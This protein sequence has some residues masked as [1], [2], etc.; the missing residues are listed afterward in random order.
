M[1][2]PFKCPKCGGPY[3]G[4]DTA[5][6]DGKVAFLNTVACHCD[7]NGGALSFWMNSESGELVPRVPRPG[8][9]CGWRG[10]WD[11]NWEGA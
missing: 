4:R 7:E 3:C 8:K 2:H 5:R 9:P 11:T 10:E 6:V 1:Q